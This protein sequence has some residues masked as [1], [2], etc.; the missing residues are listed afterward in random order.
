MKKSIIYI[1]VLLF[2]FCS[3]LCQE[4]TDYKK[5]MRQAINNNDLN[6]ALRVYSSAVEEDYFDLESLQ[7]MT[8]EIYYLQ[9]DNENTLTVCK[10][11]YN[12]DETN[13][14]TDM[15]YMCAL[16]KQGSQND[17]LI[18]QIA[19][20]IGEEPLEKSILLNMKMLAKNDMT[21]AASA[22]SRYLTKFKVDELEPN[23]NNSTDIQ[24]YKTTLT[25]LY[26]CSEKYID[27]YNSSIDYL[28]MNSQAV[29]YYILGILR[30]KRR[31]YSS[32]ASF[33]TMA[34]KNGYN[35]YDAYLQRAICK[36]WEKDY[37][38][39][40]ADLDTC[41]MIDS[42]YYAFYLK[43]I[44]YARLYQY[45]DAMLC[46]DY[47]ITLNDTFADSYNYRGIVSSNLKEYH[48][49]VLDFKHALSL[50][51]K[52][53]FAHNNLGIAYEHIGKM[54]EAIEE[55]KL[56][57]KYEPNFEGGWYNLGRVY[58]LFG[59]TGKAIKCL[60]KAADIDP[61]ISD[62]YYLLG[63]NYRNKSDKKTACDYFH[64]ALELDHTEAQEMIDNYCNKETVIIDKRKSKNKDEEQGYYEDEDIAAEEEIDNNEESSD[65]GD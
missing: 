60:N 2:A 57:V 51:K 25:L 24:A 62:I 18:A 22:I 33:L 11:L 47:S 29:I 40:N 6:F 19:K 42:N 8:A 35:H 64:R 20:K 37:I 61:E 16:A 12:E 3:C 58:T 54:T 34:I 43:G 52:T 38:A 65:N 44:N 41:I 50:N 26:F 36:G 23:N 39:S 48:F 14:I 27:A 5:I 56:S 4:E 46:F 17:S 53:P 63:I 49:A 13:N 31:E 21:K 55:Y 1:I 28:N 9:N 7:R 59:M 15:I 45:Q 30:E 32:A 10:Y